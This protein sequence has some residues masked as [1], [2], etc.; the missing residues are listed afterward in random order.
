MGSEGDWCRVSCEFSTFPS[1]YNTRELDLSRY[2]F[3]THRGICNG[4][5]TGL[6]DFLKSMIS[7]LIGPSHW[8]YYLTRLP[9]VYID[10]DVLKLAHT[11]EVTT[12]HEHNQCPVTNI[13]LGLTV[14]G[15]SWPIKHA[16][17]SC[18][19][20]FGLVVSLRI[21]QMIWWSEFAPQTKYIFLI[22]LLLESLAGN[23]Y[24]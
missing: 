24:W 3:F 16:W 2:F 4:I 7:C 5:N 19:T 8:G 18:S 1:F 23:E 13:A 20:T 22:G 12:T 21:I 9:F 15:K 17:V 6:H 11:Q 10:S 14:P